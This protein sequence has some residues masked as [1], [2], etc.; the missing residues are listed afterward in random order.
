ME[1]GLD[2]GNDEASRQ[3]TITRTRKRQGARP[4]ILGD[5][6]RP[7]TWPTD[8][9]AAAENDDEHCALV[10]GADPNAPKT[11]QAEKLSFCT[12]AICWVAAFVSGSTIVLQTGLSVV[13]SD[14]TGSQTFSNTFKFATSAL[15]VIFIGLWDFQNSVESSSK[16]MH[17]FKNDVESPELYHPLMDVSPAIR[18]HPWLIAYGSGFIRAVGFSGMVFGALCTGAYQ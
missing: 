7:T 4:F 16:L 3:F 5:N 9:E 8:V 18:K 10:G 1:L 15:L 17:F 14:V 6:P 11:V 12:Q 2:I 13:L